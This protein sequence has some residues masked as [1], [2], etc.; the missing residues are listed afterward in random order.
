MVSD[1]FSICVFL[2]GNDDH[3]IWFGCLADRY[4]CAAY[5]AAYSLRSRRYGSGWI[6]RRSRHAF[7]F[8]ALFFI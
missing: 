5:A 6:D 8:H 1:F 3:G 4:S 2:R 7:F